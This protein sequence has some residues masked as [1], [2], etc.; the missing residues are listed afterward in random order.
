MKI[1]LD[2]VFIC[3]DVGAPE[4]MHLLALGLVEGT[5]NIH[6]GQGTANRRFFFD[7]GFIELIWIAEPSEACS[8]RS[9]TARLWERW[10]ERASGACPFGIVFS[11]VGTYIP[12]PPFASCAYHPNY[13]P[14]QKPIYIA[15][16]TSMQEPALLYLGWPNP[17]QSV[18][19]EPKQHRAPLLKFQSVSVGLPSIAALSEACADASDCGLLKFH[20]SDSYEM[21]LY[22]QASKKVAFDLRAGLGLLLEGA[23]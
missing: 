16:G 19:S 23:P 7:G 5:S 2:H 4:A 13:L 1:A 12:P 21:H 18:A 14:P 6:L 22:F 9:S 10:S 3:C 15:Q 11:P 20:R 8:E 17:R